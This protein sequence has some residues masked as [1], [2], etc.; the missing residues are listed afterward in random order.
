MI[1]FASRRVGSE[2]SPRRRSASPHPGPSVSGLTIASARERLTACR[3]GVAGDHDVEPLPRWS[4]M[5]RTVFVGPAIS[6]GFD[7]PVRREQVR[8]SDTKH[9][10][11]KYQVSR[12]IQGETRVEAHLSPGNRAISPQEPRTIAQTGRGAQNRGEPFDRH[13]EH[14]GLDMLDS[15]ASSEAHDRQRTAPAPSPSATR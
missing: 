12:R 11:A 6:S 5:S 4:A 14:S 8:C 15:T 2:R 13:H 10:A 9:H 1:A 7:G 3:F